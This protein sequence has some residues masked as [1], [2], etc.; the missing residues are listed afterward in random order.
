VPFARDKKFIRRGDIIERMRDILGAE[1]LVILAGIG[2]S[3]QATQSCYTSSCIDNKQK[4]SI[5][6]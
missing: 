6:N 4:V 3:G 1:R 2:G 5:S